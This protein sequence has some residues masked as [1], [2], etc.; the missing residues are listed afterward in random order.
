M[1]NSH[2]TKKIKIRA[3]L[4]NTNCNF[5]K[6]PLFIEAQHPLSPD[7][8][9]ISSKRITCQVYKYFVCHIYILWTYQEFLLPLTCQL[10]E[11]K[12]RISLLKYRTRLV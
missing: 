2:I 3:I 7:K 12:K 6:R 8:K 4:I 1:T 11:E 10:L 9:S 5:K